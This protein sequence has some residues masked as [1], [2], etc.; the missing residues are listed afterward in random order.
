MNVVQSYLTSVLKGDFSLYE[1][2]LFCKIVEHANKALEGARVKDLA[3][4]KV[5]PDGSTARMTVAV[6][7]ILS[8]GTNDYAKVFDAAKALSNKAVEYWNYGK[9]CWSS[10][11]FTDKKG[12]TH[13]YTH[14]IDNISERDGSGVIKFNVSIWLLQY[15]LT[16]VKGAFS[17]Y[18]LQVALSLP[19]AYS[20]RMYWLTCSASRP[21]PY[22]IQMLRDMLGVGDKYKTNKDFIKRCIAAPAK[23]L[24]ERN[25]NGFT[26]K[27][28]HKNEQSRTSAIKAV[29]IIPV[30]RQL[31]TDA[32]I[33][34]KGPLSVY[35]SRELRDYLMYQANFTDRDLHAIKL[36]LSDFEKLSDWRD[37]IVRIVHH[38]RKKGAKQGY[39]VNAMKDEA[40]KNRILGDGRK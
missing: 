27:V 4:F 13:F 29:L 2:R 9:G 24:E 32:Q 20:V 30:K 11:V 39:I 17:M 7:E 10:N 37:R 14:L 21:I 36:V 40:T 3:N 1:T 28:V 22:P 16:F 8:Q 6:R 12:G 31:I 19:T 33:S 26:F 18:D 34:A 23:V 38:A 15:I 35:C 5:T 25:L